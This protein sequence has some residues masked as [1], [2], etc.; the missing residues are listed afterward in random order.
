MKKLFTLTA[1]FLLAVV[2]FSSCRKADVI[3]GNNENYWLNQEEGE[4][5]YSDP[6]C[7]Y[8]VI[9][10]YNGYQVVR[11]NSGNQPIEGELI[12]GNFSSSGPRDLYNFSGRFVFGAV[13]TDYW[14]TYSEAIDILDY[15]CPIYG[16]AA[17]EG[18]V[19]QPSTK[20]KKK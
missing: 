5:V 13:I 15:Y 19:L 8:W 1:T 12:Y 11:S 14:L 4:V 18:R 16:R 7:N 10:T 20:I 17:G 6:S 2:L 9:E 3:V